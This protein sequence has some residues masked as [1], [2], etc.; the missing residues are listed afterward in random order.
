MADAPMQRP[1]ATSMPAGQADRSP[2]FTTGVNGDDPGNASSSLSMDAAKWN[3]GPHGFTP[4]SVLNQ[5]KPSDDGMSP[6]T[7]ARVL[8]G[9]FT[10]PSQ[11]GQSESSYETSNYL[12][13]NGQNSE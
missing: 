8:P 12:K 4:E 10:L 3:E 5:L 6:S 11:N 13:M 1:Y 7:Y 2:E 9:G